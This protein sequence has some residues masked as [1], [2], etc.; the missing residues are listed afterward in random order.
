MP[1]TQGFD[2]KTF[3]ME[4]YDQILSRGLSNGLGSRE[5]TMCIEA[6]ICTVLGMK[7]SDNPKCVAESVREF[8]IALN[9]KNWSSQKARAEGLY[10][11]GL[12]Q[13]GSLGVVNDKAFCT[14][15][16]TKIIK[17]L[18]PRLFKEIFPENEICL[19]AA[20]K[21]ELEGAAYA[22]YAAYA[23]A[24]AAAN[25]ANAAYATNAAYS[26]ANAAYAAYAAANAAYA[27]YD[28]TKAVNA[29]AVDT[30]LKLAASLALEVLIELKSPGVQLLNL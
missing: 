9:D 20:N 7:H 25:A 30:Y 13:L 5:G 16:S 10:D 28:A 4:M 15:L 14:L 19:K 6:A 24:N 27:A 11:L 26:A 8:K 2:V 22:A 23:A 17:V 12:A 18:I 21:C 1:E 3:D 29:A